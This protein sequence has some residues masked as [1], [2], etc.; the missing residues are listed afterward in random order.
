MPQTVTPCIVLSGNAREAIRFYEQVLQAQVLH[1]QTY[2]EMPFPCPDSLKECIS[3]ALLRIG[4]S[5]LTLFDAPDS[6]SNGTGSEMENSASGPTVKS[7]VSL[8]ISMRDV[9]QTTRT[10]EALQQGGKVIAPLEKVSFSPAFG[11]VTDKFDV[12]FLL[13]TK[14]TN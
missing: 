10:F 1:V 7:V 11:T 3:N 5:E 9:E 12:T 14:Q 8:Q 4:E 6:A 2:G 13:V